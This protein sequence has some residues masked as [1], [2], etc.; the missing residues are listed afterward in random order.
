M[1]DF[2]KQHK[3]FSL[4]TALVILIVLIAIFAPYLTPQDP[5]DGNMKNVLQTPSAEHLLG[6]CL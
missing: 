3:L 2:I 5:Y 6:T 4:Y 1:T